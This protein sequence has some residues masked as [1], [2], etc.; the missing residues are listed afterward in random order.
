MYT[1]KL[2]SGDRNAK[3]GEKE[4]R[5]GSRFVYWYNLKYRRVG[6][7][8]QDRYKSEAV[9][10]DGY[11]LTVL[12]YIIQN[13]MKAGLEPAPGFYCWS[14]YGSYLGKNDGL[15]DT[16]TAI[17]MVGGSGELLSFFS[18]R[19]DDILLDVSCRK[20]G[21]TEEQAVGALRRLSGCASASAFQQLS[22]AHRN[23][24]LDEGLSVRQISRLTGV[25]KSSVA[26]RAM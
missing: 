16:E 26:R 24:M 23:E 1:D 20:P 10:T 4:K 13:P 11:F 14:S 6:H 21:L 15:T 9:E 5:L 12:R 18:E 22:S 19:N 3:N 25:P 7:L 8:F 2:I 17:A